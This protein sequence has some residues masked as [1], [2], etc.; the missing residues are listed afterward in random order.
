M[1]AKKYISTVTSMQG[2]EDTLH[3]PNGKSIKLIDSPGFERLRD[4]YW[5]DHK[6]RAKAVLFVID[7][8][9]FTSNG[10]DVAD[11]VYNYLVDPFIMT[12]KTP[13][14]MVCTKQDETRAKSSKV[15]QKQLEREM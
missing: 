5:D 1:I 3:L 14:L 15:I 7:S 13:F 2:L 4:K 10:K 9:D 8:T 6:V 11:L 12:N